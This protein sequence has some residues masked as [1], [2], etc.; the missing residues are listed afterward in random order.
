MTDGRGT[1]GSRLARRLVA[2]AVP[3]LGAPARPRGRAQ[4]LGQPD[5]PTRR[6]AEHPA[7]AL[8]A[9]RRSRWPRS[10]TGCRC[11]APQPAGPDPP[12]GGAGSRRVSATRTP[13]RS[14][15][16]S[17]GLRRDPSG[18]RPGRLRPAVGEFL[19]ALRDCDATNGPLPGQH[20]WW[21]G[22]PLDYYLEEA[23]TA[24][25]TVADEVDGVDSPRRAR[26]WTRRSPAPG[27][28]AGLVPRGHRLRQP[29]GTGRPA[30]GGDRLRH[31]RH[32]R[33]GLRR[34]AGLDPA[35]GT[36]GR[37]REH[38]AWTT[39]PGPAA[40]AGGCGRR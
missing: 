7:P 11:S 38:S 14:T 2:A 23:R 21:R 6:P 27:R 22:G 4:R 5:L 3:A 24:L 30:G 17:T 29:A 25:A 36:A 39:T 32:R 40:E 16:G 20:N 35:S 28:T 37:V 10:S 9:L 34:R 8:A 31:Q 18:R 33:P 26:S 13:G 1:T 12:T 15:P 19:V